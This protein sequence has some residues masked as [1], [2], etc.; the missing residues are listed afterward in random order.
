MKI[1]PIDLETMTT[2]E[3]LFAM[4]LLHEFDCAKAAADVVKVRA[5]LQ[6]VGVD[7]PSIDVIVQRV[8]SANKSS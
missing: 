1:D 5:L 4:G 3:R 6:I 2:N 7:E 8:V